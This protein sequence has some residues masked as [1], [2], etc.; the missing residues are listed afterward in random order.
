MYL[1]MASVTMLLITLFHDNEAKPPIIVAYLRKPHICNNM[2]HD[3][4]QDLRF[5]QQEVSR[6]LFLG[7]L[8][9]VVW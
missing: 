2:N 8:H 6:Y 9:H 7:I 5:S 1:I 3:T 4:S